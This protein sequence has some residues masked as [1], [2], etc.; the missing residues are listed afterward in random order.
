M[1]QDSSTTA[2]SAHVREIGAA[3]PK[4]EHEALRR[5]Y[6]DLLKLSLCDLVGAETRQVWSS[7][8]S[9]LFSRALIGETQLRW[10]ADGTDWPLNGLTMIG[11]TRLDD[12]QA[13]VESIVAD[14]I[15]GDLIE[16][17]TWRG[18]ASMLMRAT[19]DT[20]EAPQRDVWLAD[21]FQGFPLPEARG[22]D[23][24]LEQDMSAIDYLAPDVDDVRGYF[25]RL[26]L[27]GGV[28]FVPGFFEETMA[29]MRGRQWSLVRLDADTYR[30]T[31]LTL[32]ALYPGLAVGGYLVIDDYALDPCRQAVEDFRSEHDITEPIERVDWTAHRWRRQSDKP[33]ETTVHRA[34]EPLVERRVATRTGEPVPTDREQQFLEELEQMRARVRQLEEELQ[35]ARELKRG[36]AG[37]RP[38]D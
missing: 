13:C 21:S 1:S 36:R 37:D 26:G 8:P 14:G 6:L 24:E 27:D 18:G 33:I 30:A 25:G 5:A 28:R 31:R 35:A 19:L 16:A 20:L 17:G 34:D 4:P 2:S 15:P 10:R 12:L 23:R 7:N 29:G 22:T 11:L 3:G 38:G 9:R 32:E